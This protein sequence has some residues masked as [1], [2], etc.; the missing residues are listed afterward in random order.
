[1]H[2]IRVLV[3]KFQNVLP[4]EG[5]D[6]H[7]DFFDDLTAHYLNARYAD[8]KQKLSEYLDEPTAQNFLKQTKEVFAWLLTL[9]Q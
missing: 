8:Y 6:S 5:I 3:E 9:K 2:N 1:M 7:F 4:K